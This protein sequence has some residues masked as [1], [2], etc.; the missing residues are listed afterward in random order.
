[1]DVICGQRLP[2]P[3]G[4]RHIGHNEMGV[5]LRIKIAG[6]IMREGCSN[7]FAGGNDGRDAIMGIPCGYEFFY[8]TSRDLNS[9]VMG[10]KH[11]LIIT[12]QGQNGNAF[13][14]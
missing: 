5:Q 12:N 4:F 14:G 7:H 13:W 3:L 8:V 1:M 2:L 10:F 6:C 11:P 9:L